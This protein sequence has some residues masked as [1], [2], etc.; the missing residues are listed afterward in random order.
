MRLDGI[1]FNATENRRF[2]VFEVY[3]GN[4]VDQGLKHSPPKQDVMDRPNFAGLSVS[5]RMA[6]EKGTLSFG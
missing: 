3:Q 6:I 2:Q 1:L 5:F 4:A